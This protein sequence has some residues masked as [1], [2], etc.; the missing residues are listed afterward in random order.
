MTAPSFVMGVLKK[1]MGV[2]STH[3]PLTPSPHLTPHHP[4]IIPCH[5]RHKHKSASWSSPTLRESMRSAMPSPSLPRDAPLSSKS[6]SPSSSSLR[7]SFQFSRPTHLP[8]PVKN[9][10]AFTNFKRKQRNSPYFLSLGS[11]IR[12]P[13]SHKNALPS[14]PFTSCLFIVTFGRLQAPWNSL[15]EPPHAVPVVHFDVLRLQRAAD[16]VGLFEVS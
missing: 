6:S 1:V 4:N 14:T 7:I 5:T 15:H 11:K 8:S 12:H 9:D 16:G 2:S 13:Y 10:E 3:E